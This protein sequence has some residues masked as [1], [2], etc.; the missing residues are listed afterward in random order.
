MGPPAFWPRD[1]RF[2]WLVMIMIIMA[3]TSR[4]YCVPGTELATFCIYTTVNPHNNLM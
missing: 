2:F 3:S 1:K 4:N